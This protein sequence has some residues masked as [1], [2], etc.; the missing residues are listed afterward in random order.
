MNGIDYVMEYLDVQ[1]LEARDGYAK[2]SM[3][4]QKQHTNALGLTHGSVIFALADCA[5]ADASN[6]GDNVAVAAQVS[7][8][9]L[10]PTKE[11]D[12][13]T[14]EAV[15]VSDGKTLSVYAVTVRKD[16]KPVALFNGLAYKQAPRETAKGT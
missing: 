16:D 15:R 14:A 3:K 10:R 2:M 13:L 5:F 11:G 9:Y 8:N 7:I 6:F 12:V 4:I 1:H